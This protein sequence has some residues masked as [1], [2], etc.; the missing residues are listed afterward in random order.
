MEVYVH[1]TCTSCKKAEALLS[2]AGVAVERRDYFRDRF[3]A[4]ELRAL[5]GRAGLSAHDVLSMRSRAYRDQG[6]AERDLS[7]DDLI[8]LMVAEPTLLRRPIVVGIGGTAV[9]FD[10][11]KL[12]TLAAAESAAS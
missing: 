1:P 9:G 8:V 11:G 12:E 7:E 2:E 5:L 3:D 10:R 4:E 6:L